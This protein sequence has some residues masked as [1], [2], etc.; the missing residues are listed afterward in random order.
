MLNKIV[1]VVEDEVNILKNIVTILQLSGYHCLQATN[2]KEAIEI[3]INN[4][5]PNIILSDVMMPEM[6]GFE[7]LD[8]VLKSEKL[9][10]IPFCFLTALAD[11]IEIDKGLAVGAKAYITKPFSTKDLINTINLHSL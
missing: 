11:V 5:L 9:S 3:L 4:Q 8:Y 10:N 2:G 1:L 7:L 6:N